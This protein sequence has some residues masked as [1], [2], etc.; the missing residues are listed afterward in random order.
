M[1]DKMSKRHRVFFAAP[2]RDE[3]AWVRSALRGAAEDSDAEFVAVD[4]TV[5]P[6]GDIPE[7]ISWEIKKSTVAFVVI[8]QLNPNVMYE[9]GLLHAQ[10][11]P[12]IILTDGA[13][14][15]DIPFDIRHLN[16]LR[17]DGE[18]RNE[19]QL[20]A[21]ASFAL[22]RIIS[23]IDDPS[24]RQAELSG[25]PVVPPNLAGFDS[26]QLTIAQYDM[27]SIKE[28]AA[29]RVGKK[30]CRTTN[31]SEVDTGDYGGWRIKAKC[32]GGYTMEVWVDVNGD[33][34]EIDVA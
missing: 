13:E 25:T 21:A 27:E 26:V 17:Y 7:A 9:L 1:P 14:V 29:K 22:K 19:E 33:I 24:A 10:S 15:T 11:K 20:E 28:T 8:S 34:R 12:T 32:S 5:L 4:E 23:L 2:F 16:V 30:M 18:G 31:I 6:G 3:L